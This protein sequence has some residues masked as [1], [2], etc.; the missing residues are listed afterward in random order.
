MRKSNFN[1]QQI[2]QPNFSFQTKSKRLI[3][4]VLHANV[5]FL[6]EESGASLIE[7]ALIGSLIAAV[8]GLFLLVL[9]KDK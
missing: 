7:C 6:K 4:K 9:N 5:N 2:C 1:E 3:D 8:A